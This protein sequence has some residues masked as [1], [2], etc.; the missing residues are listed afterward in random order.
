MHPFRTGL[1]VL[2]V[3]LLAG[4]SGHAP[5]PA[6]PRPSSAEAAR[7]DLRPPATEL[8]TEVIQRIEQQ[9]AAHSEI[10]GSLGLVGRVQAAGAMNYTRSG[11]ELTLRG[12]TTPNGHQPPQPIQLSMVDNVG[13]LAT[14]L[15]SPD[16]AKPWVKIVPGGNDFGA[17]L[18]S[19][20]LQQLREAVDPR[21]TFSGV[22][23]AT[24]I[25]HSAPDQVNGLP[26]TRY[27]LRIITA[28]AAEIAP[29]PQQRA[30][31]RNALH[32]G[33]RELGYQLWVDGSGLPVRFAAQ[34]EV[35]QAGE[36]AVTTTY[37]N[38]G[39]PVE[40]NTPPADEVGVL[41]DLPQAPPPQ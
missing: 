22:E 16:P 14:P 19:P 7:P 6:P 2:L 20:A 25:H 23:A 34:D 15:A 24:R 10:Q 37:R 26:T 31:F 5:D 21:T 38:W 29:D 9:G 40:I 18:L 8:L 12:H 28:R 36:V 39:A 11:T 4:C 27:D 13:Y 1:L 35:A 30:R 17:R 32:S 41:Q 3:A 33:K